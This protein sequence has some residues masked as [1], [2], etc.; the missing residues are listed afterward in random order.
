MFYVCSQNPYLVKARGVMGV[1]PQWVG[2][3][4][5]V[6]RDSRH[7]LLNQ[8]DEFCDPPSCAEVNVIAL[9]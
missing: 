4:P 5:H 3:N 7:K 9:M 2:E 6:I 1:L 8:K